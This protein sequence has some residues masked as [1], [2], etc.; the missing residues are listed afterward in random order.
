MILIMPENNTTTYNWI[1]NFI[2]EGFSIRPF[3]FWN[4]KYI[5]AL[6]LAIS[7]ISAGAAGLNFL[8]F[9]RSRN[10][11]PPAVRFQK[12]WWILE[13]LVLIIVY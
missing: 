1:H 8:D 10:T 2:V 7:H 13:L 3:L 5:Q 4:R 9:E 12:Y 6:I 11:A